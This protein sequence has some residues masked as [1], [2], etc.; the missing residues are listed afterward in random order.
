M[1]EELTRQ[2]SGI[3]PAALFASDGAI[4]YASPTTPEI[5]GFAPEEA[6]RFNALELVHPDHKSLFANQ[7][8]EL[9]KYPGGTF[10]MEARVRHK[11]GSWRWLEG[12][13]K[14]L[15]QEPSVGAIVNQ[16]RDITAHKQAEEQLRRTT[17]DLRALSENILSAREQ[18]GSRIAREIHDEQN[19]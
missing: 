15:L 16:Y 19:A 9:V 1:Y 3:T 6:I 7:L 18:E 12:T 17:E 11:D 5:L 10:T 14:N 13:F 4:M 2:F 8:S